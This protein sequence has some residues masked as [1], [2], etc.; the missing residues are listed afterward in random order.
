MVHVRR[1]RLRLSA[2][3]A[4]IAAAGALLA[5]DTEANSL[6]RLQENAAK[7]TTEWNL[8]ATNL[9]QRL[10]RLLPCDPRVRTSIEEAGRAYDARTVALTSY[11][12]MVSI[13][14]KAQIEA[15]R[16]LL[17]EEE[18][19]AGDWAKDHTEAQLD[20][21]T[22]AAQAAALGPA[23]RQLPA[24]ANPQKNLEAIAQMYRTIEGQT[25]ERETSVGQLVDDLRE[26]LKSSQTRQAAIEDQLK[27]IGTEGQ[28]WSGYYAAR[29][30][31][32]QIECS[33]VNPAAAAAAARAS[34]SP[35]CSPTRSRH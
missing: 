30:L 14:S 28:R 32:A 16:G 26:L 12:T 3:A 33:I 31:R 15:I 35:D 17:A 7:R 20:V 25:Q 29:Q 27:A 2:I 4:G 1:W 8:L 18:G 11:W 9:E 13:K 21:A 10:A 24:L 6:A 22:T 23:I 5:Q 19:R 34:G